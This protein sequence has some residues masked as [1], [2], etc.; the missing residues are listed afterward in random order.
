MSGLNN[1]KKIAVTGGWGYGNLGDDAILISIIKLWKSMGIEDIVV[2]TWEKEQSLIQHFPDINFVKS[3]HKGIDEKNIK[4][5]FIPIGS[6]SFMKSIWIKFLHKLKYL[7]WMEKLNIFS[8]SNYDQIRQNLDEVDLLIVGGGGY[9]H[10]DMSFKVKSIIDELTI[11]LELGIPFIIMGVTL[12]KLTDKRL[13]NGLYNVLGKTRNIWVRDEFSYR[14]LKMAG[15]SSEIIPDVAFSDFNLS[16]RETRSNDIGFMITNF[17][18]NMFVCFAMLINTLQC[19]NKCGCVVF[20]LSRLWESDLETSKKFINI[21]RNIG[22]NFSLNIPGNIFEL[23]DQIKKMGLIVSENLHGL[24]V[25]VRNGIPVIAINNY[26]V[27]NHG[28]RKLSGTMKELGAENFIIN[29]HTDMSAIQEM[30]MTRI[31]DSVEVQ[32]QSFD[33]CMSVSNKALAFIEKAIKSQ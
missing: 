25:A 14:E 6:V 19:E 27:G 8:S 21:A 11:A 7:K 33:I 32:K 20:L 26:T 5:K 10:N 3:N 28:D 9:L 1:L 18:E 31:S 16:E 13:A 29:K 24:I 4:I 15:I 2:F 30:I 12:G 23:E 22:L 17:E